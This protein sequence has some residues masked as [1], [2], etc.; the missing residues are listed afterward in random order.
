MAAKGGHHVSC[1]P[2]LPLDPMLGTSVKESTEV[3]KLSANKALFTLN[4]CFSIELQEWVQWQQNNG[5]HTLR[6]H[7]TAKIKEKPKHRR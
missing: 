4:V 1:P 2:T 6:L 7:L 3:I 5:A